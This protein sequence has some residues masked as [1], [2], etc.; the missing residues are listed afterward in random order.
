[1]PSAPRF[2]R[3]RRLSTSLGPK[4]PPE[5]RSTDASGHEATDRV[6]VSAGEAHAW[7]TAKSPRFWSRSRAEVLCERILHVLREGPLVAAMLSK[8][9]AALLPR[10][11]P[12]EMKPE[13]E[14]LVK[15]GQVRL[16]PPVKGKTCP[17]GLG[18]PDPS[19]YLAAVAKAVDAVCQRLAPHGVP[20]ERVQHALRL[21]LGGSPDGVAVEAEED[22]ARRASDEGRRRASDGSNGTLCGGRRIDLPMC[23]TSSVL[24]RWEPGFRRSLALARL[25]VFVVSR[26]ETTSRKSASGQE[27]GARRAFARGRRAGDFE[28]G[29]PGIHRV[30]QRRIDGRVSPFEEL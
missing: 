13:L 5:A 2:R 23:R 16:H 17:Y 26:G 24:S 4:G 29:T 20:R 7:G 27:D 30:D 12:A 22:G 9:V 15:E 10:C 14:L 19:L 25:V 6:A 21:T 8:R 28:P 18:P 1:M 3:P 11:A